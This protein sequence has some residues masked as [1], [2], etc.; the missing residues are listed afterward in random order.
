MKKVDLQQAKALFEEQGYRILKYRYSL[1]EV[2]FEE[3]LR[4]IEPSS[5]AQKYVDFYKTHPVFAAVPAGAR[6]HHWWKGGLEEH[7]K[8]MIGIGFDLLQLYA[9]DLNGQVSRSDIIIAVFLHDFA[10][11]WAYIPITEEER[12]KN[13]DKYLPGQQF[14]FVKDKF[15]T[16]TDEHKTAVELMQYG[17]PVTEKQWSAVIFSE[18]GWS[19]AH[20]SFEGR[21]F[22]SQHAFSSNPLAVVMHILDLYSS[23]ILGKSLYGQAEE[24]PTAAE[25]EALAA[26]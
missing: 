24:K 20:F 11:I 22:T 25:T 12:A 17:V 3:V 2:P 13:P 21:S 14:R 19:D 5:T 8:E 1:L 10:K 26:Q 6:H 23:M 15:R 4:M 7:C 18:G 9:G 16:L